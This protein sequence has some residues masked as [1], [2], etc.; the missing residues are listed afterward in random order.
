MVLTL[1]VGKQ[2]QQ[3][4]RFYGIWSHLSQESQ[5]EIHCSDSVMLVNER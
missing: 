5:T 2:K 1:F 4:I 3:C